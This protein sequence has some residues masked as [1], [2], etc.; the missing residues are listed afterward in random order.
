MILQNISGARKKGRNPTKTQCAMVE[1]KLKQFFKIKRN[2]GS[3]TDNSTEQTS[4]Y[5]HL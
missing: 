1:R 4:K 3:M 2:K 5:F